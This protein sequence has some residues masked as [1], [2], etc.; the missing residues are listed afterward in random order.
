M[1]LG[2]LM[3][4]Q[5]AQKVGMGADLYEQ[6][7]AYKETIDEASQVLGY[8]IMSTIVNDEENVKQTKFTQPAIL[9]MSTGIYRAL[10]DVMPAPQATLG[11]SLGEYSALVAADVLTFDQAM[12]II[13][14]RGAYMQQAG[15][16]NPGKMVAVMTEDQDLV[17]ATINKLQAAGKRVYPA[18]YNTFNQLVIGGVGADVDAAIAALTDAGIERLV[19]LPVSGPFHT[20]LMQSAAD[21]LTT[22]LADEPF[23]SMSFD[24]Y[25]NTTGKK[26]SDVKTTLLD[27]IVSPTY[28]AQALQAMVDDG[29]DTLIEFGPSDT[30]YKFARKIVGKDIKRYKVTNFKTYQEVREMLAAE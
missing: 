1:K 27:Q 17:I 23:S 12:R 18:N 15:D 6:V 19:E 7:P 20:P 3:S 9:A 29:V 30:L 16:D 26:F 24:V 21:Q 13:K 25:S 2:I 5:G 10:A 11:L 14:D 8:D 28:F 22:R 4:G